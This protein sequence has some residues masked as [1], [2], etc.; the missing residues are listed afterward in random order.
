MTPSCGDVAVH[1]SCH[2]A[3][4]CECCPCI[5]AVYDPKLHGPGSLV[6]SCTS[7]H[8]IVSTLMWCFLHHPPPQVT[9]EEPTRE[10]L[11][12]LHATIKKVDRM[13]IVLPA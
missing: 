5:F 10:Q 12:L 6:T 13:H 11:R 7:I 8:T 1:H 9:D 4:P 3:A 2:R